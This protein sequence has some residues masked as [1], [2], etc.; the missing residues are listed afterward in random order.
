MI[1]FADNVSMVVTAKTEDSLM[2]KANTC[3][4][5]LN[6]WMR[7]RRVEIAKGLSIVYRIITK[8]TISP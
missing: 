5:L 4:L 3:L 8:E 6:N 2:T 1:G 7:T